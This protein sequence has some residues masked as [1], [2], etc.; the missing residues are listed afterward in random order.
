MVHMFLS[1]RIM[2]LC[3][4]TY[5]LASH[6]SW[7]GLFSCQLSNKGKFYC[8]QPLLVTKR[9]IR[10]IV[11][12]PFF[13]DDFASRRQ[14]EQKRFI[15]AV[16]IECSTIKSVFSLFYSWRFK[17]NSFFCL[18][19]QHIFFWKWFYQPKTKEIH[20]SYGNSS[21]NKFRLQFYFF[22][23]CPKPFASLFI[24]WNQT[25]FFGFFKNC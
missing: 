16:P 8:Q 5:K 18:L 20:F 9:V 12:S 10:P 2:S 24:A 22:S 15:S 25:F 11:S 7:N 13:E 4:F 19:F 6:Q 14:D 3:S 23:E 17:L 1:S 21:R